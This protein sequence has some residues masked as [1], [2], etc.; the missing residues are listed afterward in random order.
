MTKNIRID[1]YTGT[2]GAKMT[3]ELLAEK[4]KA[5]NTN[6]EVNRIKRSNISGIDKL[7]IDYYILIF[8]V[9]AFNAPK[10][11]YEWVEH[12]SGN[13]CK[14]AVIS[15]SGA[16]NVVSNSASR[17]KTVKLLKKS[18]FNVIFEEMIRMPNNW[19]NVPGEKKFTR[20]LSKIPQKIEQISQ[21]ILAEKKR[22]SIVYWIDYL[23]SALG[24]MEKKELPKFGSGIKVTD[25][26]T[27][28]GLC[29]KNCC[30]ANIQMEE[31]SSKPM[32]G[33]H[34]DMCLG[35]IYNCPQ[36]ALQPTVWAFQVDKKGYD[37][38]AMR[39]IADMKNR[40]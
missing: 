19:M 25:D 31:Q 2:G 1:Y 22:S 40:V 32:F 38:N 35:C 34:C 12:L 24:E 14:T 17:H 20:I 11:V 27:G 16:G 4:L 5:S 9:H 29:A 18:N 36:K 8:P 21:T 26:C 33:N 37:L 23:I 3:A 30:S 6:V 13:G 39:Q 7:D 10:S 28:C 15:I